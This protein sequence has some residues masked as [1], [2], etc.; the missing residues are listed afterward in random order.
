M[1]QLHKYMPK[2]Y[3]IN[4]SAVFGMCLTRNKAKK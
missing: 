3:F 2:A 4:A 1:Y